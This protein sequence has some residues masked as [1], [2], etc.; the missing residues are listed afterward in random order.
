MVVKLFRRQNF[1]MHG[2]ATI[3]PGRIV[4][5]FCCQQL[6]RHQKADAAFAIV[7]WVQTAD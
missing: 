2:F 4:G 7:R 5:I 3:A 6:E 1:P